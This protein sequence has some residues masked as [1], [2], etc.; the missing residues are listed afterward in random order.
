MLQQESLRVNSPHG[1]LSFD[2]KASIERT[3]TL[4]LI[5]KK[6]QTQHLIL[7]GTTAAVLIG[8]LLFG[9]KET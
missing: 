8:S 7:A 9:E 5:R 4:P 1:N 6:V 2:P 3:I